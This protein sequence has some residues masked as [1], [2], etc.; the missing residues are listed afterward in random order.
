[1][2]AI[3]IVLCAALLLT[4]SLWLADSALAKPA[5]CDCSFC[6][7]GGPMSTCTDPVTGNVYSLL[8]WCYYNCS[9][10]LTSLELGPEPAPILSTDA[11]CDVSPAPAD[12]P[13]EIDLQV[14]PQPSIR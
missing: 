4:G 14:Q 6:S 1:M 11:A 9:L 7:Q 13:A 5:T 10:G 12:L 2:K 8:E 3:R